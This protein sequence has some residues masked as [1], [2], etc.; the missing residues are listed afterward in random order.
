MS[1]LGLTESNRGYVERYSA[2]C[3]YCRSD[4][5]LIE[6]VIP[7]KH[8]SL[9][10]SNTVCQLHHIAFHCDD[11]ATESARLSELGV[12][13]V[14]PAPVKAADQTLCN[15]ISPIYTGGVLLELVSDTEVV[16]S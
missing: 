3:I 14:E 9:Y 15:F 7:D 16:T 12:S 8:S 5:I 1:L 2:T 6:F 11:F 10:S 4:K 13:L